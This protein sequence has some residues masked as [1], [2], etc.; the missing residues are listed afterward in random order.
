MFYR[1]RAGDDHGADFR[2]HVMS[3]GHAGGGAQIFQ[4]RVGAGADE[5]TIDWNFFDSSAGFQPH[6]FQHALGGVAV[7]FG[8]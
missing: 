3:L 1:L 5:D 7:G 6:V 2:T 8:H 4:T